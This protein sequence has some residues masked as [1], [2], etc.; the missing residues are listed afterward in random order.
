MFDVTTTLFFDDENDAFS[1]SML[2]PSSF[3]VP[4]LI[5]VNMFSVLSYQLQISM[6]KERWVGYIKDYDGGTLMECRINPKVRMI[7]RR[8]LLL[9]GEVCFFLYKEC[10][11][12]LLTNS[13]ASDR[14][15]VSR[16]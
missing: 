1:V 6:P 11:L 15:C 9:Y 14:A 4:Y 12:L 10:L 7:E 8:I 5:S 3:R 13:S 2:S 16:G